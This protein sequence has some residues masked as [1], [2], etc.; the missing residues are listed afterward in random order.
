M[1]G[2]YHGEKSQAKKDEEKKKEKIKESPLS[3]DAQARLDAL[4]NSG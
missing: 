3:K 2:G 1:L 4:I